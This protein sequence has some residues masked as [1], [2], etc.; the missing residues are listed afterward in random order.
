MVGVMNTFI[1]ISVMVILAYLGTSYI[2]YTL[3]G[4]IAGI[5][6]SYIMNSLFTYSPGNKKNLY[7]KFFTINGGLILC[8]SVLQYL[9]IDVLGVPEYAGV[10]TGVVFFTVVSFLI[11]KH[12]VFKDKT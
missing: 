1:S 2:V 12:Y 5:T 8:T 7:L 9:I 10:F 6:N 4:Y 3:S 11:N